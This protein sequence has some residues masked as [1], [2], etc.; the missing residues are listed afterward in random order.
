MVEKSREAKGVERKSKEKE[1]EKWE[2]DRDRDTTI[3]SR[4]KIARVL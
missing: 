3:T 2:R 4:P 1:K